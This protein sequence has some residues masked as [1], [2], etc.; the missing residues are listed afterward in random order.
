LFQKKIKKKIKK[1]INKKINK[2]LFST[3]SY[4]A[5]NLS[6]N[7]PIYNNRIDNAIV[8]SSLQPSI[9][10]TLKNSEAF[11][12]KVM[13]LYLATS[14]INHKKFYVMTLRSLVNSL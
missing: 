12:K 11:F 8:L 14:R 9:K 5:F 10:S 6:H 13:F 7:V 4:T 2:K 3:L 1:K